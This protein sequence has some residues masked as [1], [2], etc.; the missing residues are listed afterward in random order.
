MVNQ[1][2]ALIRSTLPSDVELAIDT[3]SPP[4]W[5]IADSNLWQQLLLNLALNSRDAMPDGGSLSISIDR[6]TDEDITKL[7][8]EAVQDAPFALIEV[9]DTGTGMTPE[10]R[11]H[12]LEPFYTTKPR[13]QGTGLGLPIVLGIVQDHNGVLEIETEEGKGCKI[14]I[15]L[16]GIDTD[17]GVGRHDTMP[18]QISGKGEFILF[19]SDKAAERALI[20]TMLQSSGY[21]VVQAATEESFRAHFESHRERIRLLLIDLH[22]SEDDGL[23]CLRRLRDDGA[24]TAAIVVTGDGGLQLEAPLKFNSTLLHQPFQM[25]DLQRLVATCVQESCETTEA[26]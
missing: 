4:V 26:R 18:A 19:L 10:V 7:A 5:V 12:A 8:G 17:S 6:A 3:C 21:E 15:I 22:Q 24:V 25:T 11:S 16:P 20:T 13:G 23:A 2:A 9:T 14:R 1:A